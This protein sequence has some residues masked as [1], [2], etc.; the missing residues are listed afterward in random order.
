MAEKSDWGKPN[1]HARGM[2]FTDAFGSLLAQVVELSVTRDRQVHVHRVTNALDAGRVL[3]R[4]IT[5]SNIQGGVVWG[6]SAAFKSAITFRDGRPAQTNFHDFQVVRMNEM[7]ERIDVHFI[8]SGETIGG[9]GEIGPVAIPPAV[10][11]AIFAATG[12][13]VRSLPLSKHGFTLI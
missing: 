7:P 1:G 3:D 8:D 12:E 6:L 2:A 5:T 11:N 10:G 13:R 4:G 9:V